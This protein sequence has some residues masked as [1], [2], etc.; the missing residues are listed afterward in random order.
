MPVVNLILHPKFES[1]RSFVENLPDTFSTSGEVIY[2]GR[3]CL[4]KFSIHNEEF[5]VKSFKKPHIINR[6]AYTFFR[7]SKAVRSYEHSLELLQA[8]IATPEPVAYIEIKTGGLLDR[9][10][11]INRY[12]NSYKHI[13]NQ[14]TGDDIPDGFIPAFAVFISQMHN[15]GIL[16]KDLS[17]GNVLFK[18]IGSEFSFMVVDINRMQFKENL[19]FDE[20]CEN[21]CRLTRN[22]D[23]LSAIADAYTDFNNMH[24][25]KTKEAILRYNKK[26]FR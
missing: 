5:I 2:E 23:I 4:K 20:R 12:E 6:I 1:L 14:M 17:P 25:A 10:F 13:R 9:S 11:F 18:K 8:G 15:N 7:K 22:D 19:T 3:N 16:H 26:F 21:F 24:T